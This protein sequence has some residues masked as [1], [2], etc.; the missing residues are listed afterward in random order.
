MSA[1]NSEY[2][3]HIYRRFFSSKLPN[4]NSH[5]LEQIL[6]FPC[7]RERPVNSKVSKRLTLTEVLISEQSFGIG[8][9]DQIETLVDGCYVDGYASNRKM[10]DSKGFYEIS[11]DSV[12]M[13]C[14]GL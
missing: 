6:D 2:I 11:L 10:N 1:F 14:H 5:I 9:I 3:T 7:G 13:L 12:K 4:Y 8:N